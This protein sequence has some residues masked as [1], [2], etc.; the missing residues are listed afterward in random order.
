MAQRAPAIG[1]PEQAEQRSPAEIELAIDRTRVEIAVTLDAIERRLNARY[2]VEKGLDMLKDTF[3]GGETLNQGLAVIR[4]NPVPLALIGIGAAWLIAGN[5]GVGDRLAHNE[6]IAAARRRVGGLASD[7]GDRA[8]TLASQVAGTVG[9][10][11]G[12]TGSASDASSGDRPLGHTGNSV[13]DQ[14]GDGS[15]ADGWVHQ[16]SDMAQGALRSVR[17]SG[18][19]MIN[20]ASGVAGGATQM[21]DQLNDACRRHPLLLGAIGVMAGAVVASLLPATQVE[22][23]WI[24]DTR[25][26]L[27]HKA[28]ELGQ[29]AVTR[30]REAAAHAATRAVDAAAAAATETVKEEITRELIEPTRG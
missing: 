9:G 21:V 22:E 13:V 7:I 2:L 26:E 20:R 12:I 27:W 10:A 23:E 18:G 1:G 15:E 4:A 24:G 19:A 29:T 3:S 5:T 6:S 28:E 14:V 17:D 16:V 30:V 11:V 8:G 25:D